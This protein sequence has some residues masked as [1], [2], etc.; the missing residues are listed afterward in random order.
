MT[1]LIDSESEEIKFG[2]KTPVEE[3]YDF[4]HAFKQSNDFSMD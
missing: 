3:Q 4:D 1:E 2:E